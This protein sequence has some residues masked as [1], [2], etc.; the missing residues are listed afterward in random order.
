[1]IYKENGWNFRC[2]SYLRSIIDHMD[3]WLSDYN[4][5]REPIMR[6]HNGDGFPLFEQ[7]RDD[8]RAYLN[9]LEVELN[10][11]DV[12]DEMLNYGNVDIEKEKRDWSHNIV[13]VF[14]MLILCFFLFLP[15]I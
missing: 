13:Y 2:A 11:E 6:D 10:G 5:I 7:Q 15:V 14:H 9:E 1:M 12:E 4:D 8:A 3:V